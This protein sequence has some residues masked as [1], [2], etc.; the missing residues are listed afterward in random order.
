[1]KKFLFILFGGFV[2][3]G[4]FA[5]GENVP[6]S[7]G[8]VDSKLGEKQDNIIAN[9]TPRVLTNTGVA[10]EYGTKGIYDANG[11]YA[12]QTQNLVDAATMNAGVQNAINSEFQCIEWDDHGNCLLLDVFGSTGRTSSKNLFDLNA[13]KAILNSVGDNGTK[14]IFSRTSNGLTV[15]VPGKIPSNRWYFTLFA[16]EKIN[17]FRGKTLTL[18]AKSRCENGGKALYTLTRTNDNGTS[19]PDEQTTLTIP[20]TPDD[21]MTKIAVRLYATADGAGTNPSCTYYDIMVEEGTVAT[22]YVPYGNI[23]LPTVAQ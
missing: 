23:Y 18:S 21:G 13:V 16:F 22:P 1:M 15:T 6:T 3:A 5:A 12:T 20:N 14:T 17:K 7:K 4:A 19:R 2:V 10:G 8:Y 11:E 9:D